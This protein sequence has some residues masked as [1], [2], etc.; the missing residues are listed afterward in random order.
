LPKAVKEA[1]AQELIA[2]GKRLT[3]QF[4]RSQIGSVVEV[5]AESDGAGYKRQLYPRAYR[6]AGGR[7]R[8]YPAGRIGWRKRH[9]VRS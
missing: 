8:P 5:L 7:N 1:R 9:L 6:R 2:L 4:L 3:G